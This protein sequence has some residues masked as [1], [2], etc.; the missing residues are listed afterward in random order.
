MD[1]E[2]HLFE[3]SRDDLRELGLT[4]GNVKR[5]EKYLA[6]L[7]DDSTT[8][9]AAPPAALTSTCSQVSVN[10]FLKKSQKKGINLNF[11]YEGFNV[12]KCQFRRRFVE[13][14]AGK[15]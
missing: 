3:L 4:L 10:F 7:R 14:F 13:C 5:V 12:N 8:S 11:I 15:S 6:L 1:V 2:E 9:T